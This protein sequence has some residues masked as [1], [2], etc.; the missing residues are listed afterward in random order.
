[1]QVGQLANPLSW[2]YLTNRPRS[3]YL[4]ETKICNL[5]FYLSILSCLNLDVQIGDIYKFKG[6]YVSFPRW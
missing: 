5:I 4:N 2:K 6:V 3:C 1:M